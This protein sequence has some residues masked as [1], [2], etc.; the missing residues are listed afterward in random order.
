MEVIIVRRCPP[1][2]RGR[3]ILGGSLRFWSIKEGVPR[4]RPDPVGLPKEGRAS[5]LSRDFPGRCGPR[6][7]LPCGKFS[8]R[9]SRILPGLRVQ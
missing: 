1:F 7:A 6:W 2:L 4:L 8:G 5:F 9:G 3:M